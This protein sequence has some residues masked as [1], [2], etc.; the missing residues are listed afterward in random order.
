M[1]IAS[2]QLVA[3]YIYKFLLWP[4]SVRR[5]CRAWSGMIMSW[6]IC[7]TL[8]WGLHLIPFPLPS[9]FCLSCYFNAWTF[10]WTHEVKA[11]LQMGAFQG[12]TKKLFLFWFMQT[13][14]LLKQQILFENDRQNSWTWIQLKTFWCKLVV[15]VFYD[16]EFIEVFVCID[17]WLYLYFFVLQQSS[18]GNHESS[19]I[20]SAVHKLVLFWYV[21]QCFDY[22]FIL[23]V[24][25]IWFNSCVI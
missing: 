22:D 9:F 6:K 15:Y 25:E 3:K 21:F 11:I 2:H 12:K 4:F 23:T 10:I 18:E 19:S 1:Q 7:I 13:C 17:L 5:W 14:D 8:K 24:V 16:S 20:A